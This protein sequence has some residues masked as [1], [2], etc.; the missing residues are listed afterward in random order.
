MMG[1][2]NE[3]PSIPVTIAKL[4]MITSLKMRHNQLTELP[5]AFFELSTLTSLD[6]SKYVAV[7]SF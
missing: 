1:S 2:Y 6:L 5:D 3:I 7:V 4:H